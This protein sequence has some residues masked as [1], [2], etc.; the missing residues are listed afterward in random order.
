M[1]TLVRSF[2]C[3]ALRFQ[4]IRDARIR[5][6]A[7]SGQY[8]RLCV[9]RH[10]GHSVALLEGV[11]EWIWIKGGGIQ[12]QLATPVLITW[13]STLFGACVCI[14]V[15]YVGGCIQVRLATNYTAEPL[16]GVWVRQVRPLEQWGAPACLN[17]LTG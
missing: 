17:L 5:N 15:D 6:A 7:K 11:A 13:W 3:A 12:V 10:W 8:R 9:G 16:F 1:A 4:R 14:G 2:P